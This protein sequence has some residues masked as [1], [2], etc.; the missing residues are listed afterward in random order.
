MKGKESRRRKDGLKVP[1]AHVL[2]KLMPSNTIASTSSG[3][4]AGIYGV[5]K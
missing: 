4:K 2:V 1:L 5:C 3:R